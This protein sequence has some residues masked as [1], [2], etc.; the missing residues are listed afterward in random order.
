MEN[1]I[2]NYRINESN[3]TFDEPTNTAV[4]SVQG[5]VSVYRSRTEVQKEFQ[6]LF[7]FL[8]FLLFFFLFSSLP[9][10]LFPSL[11]L[12]FPPSLPPSLF[13]SLTLSFP[14]SLPPSPPS[15]PPSIS[16]QFECCGVTNYTDWI[17][18]N[19]DAVEDNNGFIPARCFC[20]INEDNCLNDVMYNVTNV[21][22]RVR[23]HTH[24][25]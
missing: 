20:D 15:F 1:A 24:T 8:F 5:I 23:K 14:P 9:P 12:S 4:E 16:L 25:H 3:E 7:L 11:T 13:P 6:P 19:P 22:D 17:R 2:S 10:S 21:W 18:L